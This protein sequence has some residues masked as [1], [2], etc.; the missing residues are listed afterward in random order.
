VHPDLAVV[1]VAGQADPA[2]ARPGGLLV[3]LDPATAGPV[4]V[5]VIDLVALGQ[6]EL[7]GR[8]V[9]VEADLDVIGNL[10]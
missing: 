10:R 8:P 5:P 4:K 3:V 9:R 7:D 1:R 2:A 6:Q